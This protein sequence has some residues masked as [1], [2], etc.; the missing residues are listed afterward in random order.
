MFFYHAIML[1]HMAKFLFVVSF[2]SVLIPIGFLQFK[3]R[4]SLYKERTFLSVF[5]IFCNRVLYCAWITLKR[6]CKLFFSL[7]FTLSRLLAVS[8]SNDLTHHFPKAIFNKSYLISSR[9][10]RNQPSK[11]FILFSGIFFG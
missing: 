10:A 9:L 1:L 7:I 2:S 4:S 11:Q 3:G 8:V 6:L 5:F